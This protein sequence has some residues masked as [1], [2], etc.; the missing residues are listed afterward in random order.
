[1]AHRRLEPDQLA[2]MFYVRFTQE[3]GEVDFSR[4]M[5]GP[6]DFAVPLQAVQQEA[7]A[8]NCGVMVQVSLIPLEKLFPDSD[9]EDGDSEN[10]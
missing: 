7:S 6:F 10:E 5:G 8:K 2:P 3:F 9:T 1:M 4:V